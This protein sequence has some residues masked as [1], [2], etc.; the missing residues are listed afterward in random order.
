M[1]TSSSESNIIQSNHNIQDTLISQNI[2]NQEE[3]N[4]QN[5][6]KSANTQNFK[7]IQQGHSDDQVGS[8]ENLFVARSAKFSEGILTGKNILFVF[9]IYFTD[10]FVFAAHLPFS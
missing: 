10:I 5:Q 6:Q 1:A 9:K 4:P 8:S 2:Y 3:L 7:D